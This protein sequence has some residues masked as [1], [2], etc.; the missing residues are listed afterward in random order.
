MA[1]RKNSSYIIFLKK[2][3]KEAAEYAGTDFETACDVLDN[4]FETLRMYLEDPR[5][6]YIRLGQLGHFQ[7]TLGSLRKYVSKTILAYR[8]FPRESLRVLALEKFAKISKIRN[9]ISLARKKKKDGIVWKLINKDTFIQ[10]ELKRV[11]GKD[12][13]KY[14]TEDGKRKFRVDREVKREHDT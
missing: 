13:D 6:P 7:V 8:T 9:R 3:I 12:Y 2:E 4:F 14:Y 5:M 10:D 1:V 11:F